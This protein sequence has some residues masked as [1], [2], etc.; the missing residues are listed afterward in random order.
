VHTADEARESL[1]QQI[2]N[3]VRWTES[4]QLLTTS[5][6]RRCIEV[7]AG[8]VLTGLCRNIDAAIKAAKFGEPGDLDKVREVVNSN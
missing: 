6:V 4:I 8:S 2:P 1:L 5:G 3:P 7:G